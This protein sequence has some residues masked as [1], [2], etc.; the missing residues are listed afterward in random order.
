MKNEFYR[1]GQQN[2][3]YHSIIGQIAKQAKHMGAQWDTEA[4]KRLLVHQWAKETGRPT[5]KVVPSLDG[6]D[7]VQLG[8]Q[9]RSFSKDDAIEFTEFLL[10]WSAQHGV[11]IHE[12]SE[13]PVRSQSSPAPQ[14][15]PYPMP[16]LRS[17]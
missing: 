12:V 9:T 7:I 8:I 16:A 17:R 15:A 14:R 4:W 13:T 1:S 5:G 6:G 2:K 10:A 3:L 11:T